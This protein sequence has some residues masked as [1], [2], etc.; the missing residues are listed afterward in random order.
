MKV[1]G[2]KSNLT[3]YSFALIV[4]KERYYI[5]FA[6]CEYGTYEDYGVYCIEINPSQKELFE[7]YCLDTQKVCSSYGESINLKGYS[8]LD[9]K[10]IVDDFNKFD[11]G[12]DIAY[13]TIKEHQEKC[14][15]T[16]ECIP[17]H[18]NHY[19]QK[20]TNELS[21]LLEYDFE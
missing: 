4:R 3:K 17:Q 7:N 13:M 12:L 10:K 5:M 8:D 9:Y 18:G 19:L 14:K 11:L 20:K 21:K 1:I 15:K 6:I 2:G 16:L